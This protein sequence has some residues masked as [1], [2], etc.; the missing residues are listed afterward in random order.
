MLRTIFGKK[1]ESE[2]TVPMASS[3]TA[4]EFKDA[5]SRYNTVLKGMNKT[6]K[7]GQAS[8]EELDKFRYQYAPMNFSKNTGRTME[9]SDVQKLVEW[10][11]RHG[12]YRPMLGKLVASNK[13]EAIAA[14]TKD[15]FTHYGTHQA[16][17]AGTIDKLKTPLKGIGPATASLLLA[18][19]DPQNVIFFSD[20]LYRWLCNDGKKISLK[21]T[22]KEFEDVFAKAKAF[23]SRIKCTPIELEKVAFTLIQE[24]EPVYE[25]KPKKEPSGLPRGRPALPE[26]QKK[27]KK[28][29][30]PGRGRGRPAGKA[31]AAPKA[32]KAAPA[33][34]A[35]EDAPK[36]Q[37]GR[38]PAA[39]KDEPE[40]EA[41]EE[42][43]DEA[44]KT[45]ASKKRKSTATPASGRGAK[46]AKA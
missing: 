34:G 37:R 40:A 12:T 43:G 10:K 6:P 25:P 21:Y 3:I 36:K 13:N 4:A 20:E 18:I 33:E 16:D 42:E 22:T 32:K 39:K 26:S 1:E 41:D 23:M 38:P 11:V 5:L 30:V 17:I 24:N 19:H 14:A 8:F 35:A 15:A 27:A 9:L 7:E 28:P 44:T 45:P 2:T 46:K 31:A 29:T